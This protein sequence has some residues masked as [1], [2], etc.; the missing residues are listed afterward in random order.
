[1]IETNRRS[2]APCLTLTDVW[3]AFTT[4]EA[5][6]T[7][8][9]NV[10]LAVNYGEWLAIV[11]PNGGGKSTLARVMAGLCPVSRGNIASDVPVAFVWQNPDA[12]IVGDTVRED[13]Q[14]GL[15]ATG[16]AD[17]DMD[18]I[19]RDVLAQVGLNVAPDTPTDALSGG[20]QQLLATASSLALQPALIVFDEATSMLDPAARARV[21]ETARRLHTGGTTIVWVTQWLEELAYADRVIA[22]ADGAIAYAGDP[23]AFLYGDDPPATNATDVTNASVTDC[24]SPCERLG[25]EAPF[26][27]RLTRELLR[28]G[29]S[30]SPLP[31]NPEQWA[32][33]LESR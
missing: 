15:E 4:A 13:I 21:L 30:F 14:F 8:L 26:T 7:A 6:H 23:S 31:I 17:S 18:S 22:L 12:Q 27:V 2:V 29:S 1:M 24:M 5:P 10:T 19:V 33:C 28:L 25:F 20:Q 32:R 16:E 9:R 3:V 11:G